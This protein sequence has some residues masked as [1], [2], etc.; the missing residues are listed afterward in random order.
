MTGGA[1]GALRSFERGGRGADLALVEGVMGLYDG[2]RGEA[3]GRFSTAS[4]AK[5][6]KAPVIVCLSARKSGQT[7]ATQ[8]LGLM[9]AD[10]K[11]PIAGAV[12]NDCS[13]EKLY[14][15]L[16]PAF[17]ALTG[18]PL[19]GWMPR[20][21]ELELPER[22]LGLMPPSEAA[23]WMAKLDWGL[24]QAVKSVD[25][26]EM[27]KAARKAPK[28]ALPG[29][30]APKPPRQSARLAIARD[31]AFHFYYPENLA[32]LEAAGAELLP[33]SP[34]KD[35]KLPEGAQ[36]LILG[37]GFPELFGRE[38]E[39]NEFIRRQI[40]AKVL[41]G[42][43]TWAECG[44]LMYLCGSLTDLKGGRH[45]MAGALAADVL[46]TKRLQNFGYAEAKAT[47]DSVA[48]AKG[49]RLRGH[50]FHHSELFWRERPKAL[51][52]VSQSGKP[53][54]EEGWALKQ[55]I[56]TY[57]HAHLASAPASAERFTAAAAKHSTE[58]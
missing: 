25:F 19:F 33:F 29:A 58:S 55:G 30:K 44:G 48:A 15:F 49:A 37:G 10:P 23:A 12:L 41:E 31:A 14:Q 6:L 20:L 3:F 40:G 11:V 38:L 39:E 52:S 17:K 42:L 26:P 36:G 47:R 16:A 5:T 51:F 7:L 35:R 22:H 13:S 56:A 27:L 21:K 46:M 32:L 28:L 18:L 34:L 57:F 24:A 1:K 50:E 43:P 8:L 53:P 54:R 4:L 9:K 45:A 2:K